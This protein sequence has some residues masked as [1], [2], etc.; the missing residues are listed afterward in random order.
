MKGGPKGGGYRKDTRL[1]HD[2]RRDPDDGVRSEDPQGTEPPQCRRLSRHQKGGG[3]SVAY[4]TNQNAWCGQLGM[5]G[6]GGFAG[7]DIAAI[8]GR[9]DR[10]VTWESISTSK[11]SVEAQFSEQ[12]STLPV[13]ANGQGAVDTK[14]S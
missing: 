14:S 12:T 7:P 10:F 3:R 11:L 4:L 1:T 13:P 8:G 5:S 6:R 2:L 9:G